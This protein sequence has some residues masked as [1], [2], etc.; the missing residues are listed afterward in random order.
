MTDFDA[1]REARRLAEESSISGWTVTEVDGVEYVMPEHIERLDERYRL[2]G[3]VTL[4]ALDQA[5]KALG[6]LRGLAQEEIDNNPALGIPGYRKGML[7]RATLASPD[8]K[9]EL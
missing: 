1:I 5:E 4:G 8:T 7:A 9:E 3:E 2:L 6:N